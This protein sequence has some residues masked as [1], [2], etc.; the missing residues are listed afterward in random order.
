MVEMAGTSRYVYGTF[1][2]N[3]QFASGHSSHL[4]YLIIDNELQIMTRLFDFFEPFIRLPM[5]IQ[6]SSRRVGSGFADMSLGARIPVLR[7][8]AFS[9]LPALTFFT[10]VGIPTGTKATAEGGVFNEDITGS[11]AWQINLGLFLEKEMRGLTF[12]LGYGFSAETDYFT[13]RAEKP[14]AK[15]EPLFSAGYS[16][17]DCGDLS[18]TLS[19]TFQER[20]LANHKPVADSDRR[21]FTVGMGYGV[22][23]HSHLRVNAHLGT[24]LPIPHLGKKFNNDVMLRIGMRIGV[25]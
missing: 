13:G 17:D 20:G 24:D 16:L 19:A 15:H 21:K 10:S 3:G 22:S 1:D 7:E 18:A 12:G 11:G 23:L 6:M 5:R 14:G 8:G 2:K 9:Y 25:F 4:P